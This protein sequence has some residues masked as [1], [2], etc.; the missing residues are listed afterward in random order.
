MKKL[1]RLAAILSQWGQLQGRAWN[2]R[3]TL[4]MNESGGWYLEGPLTNEDPDWAVLGEGSVW[5][6]STESADGAVQ[7]LATDLARDIGYFVAAHSN[8]GTAAL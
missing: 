7:A 6:C 4:T 2:L 1:D 3:A 5:S 8:E